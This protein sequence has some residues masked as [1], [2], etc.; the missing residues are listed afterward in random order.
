MIHRIHEQNK[1]VVSDLQGLERFVTE[2]EQPGYHVSMNRIK[3]LNA[4]PK[5]QANQVLHTREEGGPRAGE[6][7]RIPA[8]VNL[9]GSL[10]QSRL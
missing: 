3:N 9:W 5:S 1:T 7:V 8:V 4:N 6:E 10:G 2:Q